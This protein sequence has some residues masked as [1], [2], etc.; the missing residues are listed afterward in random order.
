MAINVQGP[1]GSNFSFP[2]G[3]SSA[4]ITAA[5]DQ[6]FSGA[7]RGTPAADP[8]MTEGVVRSVATG[9]PV[10]GGL[11]NKLDA[12]TNAL[13]APLLDKYL[14]DS[15]AK[16][17][18]K[19][20]GERYSHALQLQK[21]MDK[22]FGAEHPV[23]DTAGQVAGG[24]AGVGA[25]L[26][27]A[28]EVTSRALGLT[29]ETLPQQVLH[30]AAGGA[31]LSA[32]DAATRGEDPE[33]SAEIGAITGAAAPVVGRVIGRGVQAL[34]SLRRPA[35]VATNLTDIAG[36]PVRQSLG[37]ATGDTEAIQ[38]EQMA[39][40]G[41]DNSSEQAVARD[42]FNRQKE[43]LGNAAHAVASQMNPTGEVVAENP[44]EMGS[45]LLDSLGQ[46][47]QAAA[48]EAAQRAQALQAQKGQV[49]QSLTAPG[50]PTGPLDAADV[51]SGEI[52]QARAAEQQQ[53]AQAAQAIQERAHALTSSLSPTGTV[54][55]A[56]PTEAANIVGQ[57]VGQAAESA[58]AATN[59]AY[60]G[61]RELPGRFDPAAFNKVGQEISGAL[62]RGA[63]PIKIDAQ[64]TPQAAAALN[65]LDEIVG[66]LRQQRDPATGQIVKG[67]P[68]TPNVVETARQ[69][70]NTFYRDALQ[71]ARASNNWADVRAMRGVMDAFDDA[72]LGRLRRG[73]FRGGD[74]QAVIDSME[75]ARGLHSNYRKTFTSQGA[76]DAVGQAM[77]KVVG[78]YEG[79]ASPPEE[80]RGML[81]GNG[82]LPVKLGQRLV[83]VFG[84]SSPEV[85]AIKQGYLSHLTQD[86]AG[87]ALAPEKAAGNIEGA[88]KSS[89]L[90]Q[91]YFSAPERQALAEHAAT[92]RA[93][94]PRP[95]A[96][97]DTVARTIPRIVGEGG[98]PMTA[99]ELADT[100]FGRQGV[101]ENQTGVKIVGHLK[102]TRG[103]QSP[104][105][106]AIRNGIF[107]RLHGADSGET[108]A[109]I[110]E[111]LNGRGKQ[112]ANVAFSPAEREQLARYGEAHAAEAARSSAPKTQ[113]DKIMDRLTGADNS[114]PPTASDVVQYLNTTKGTSRPVALVQRIKREFGEGSREVAALKQGQWAYLLENNTGPLDVGSRKVVSNIKAF[115][116]GPGKPLAHVL[117]SPQ[118]RALIK[119][120]GDLMERI[121]P[122]PGTV[123][124]SNTSTVLGKMMRGTLD[125]IF[126]AGGLHMA[127]PVGMLAGYPAHRVQQIVEDTVRASKVARS[128]YGTPQ[129]AA[130][131][132]DLARQ[133]QRLASVTA[134]AGTSKIAVG[135]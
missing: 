15:Y 59:A 68:L 2:D 128:L 13:L 114:A 11:A 135:Q 21:S 5:L 31:A 80:V 133:L 77:Q 131:A 57:S 72:V 69:R 8:G 85:G 54:L 107:N 97:T 4:D 47:G 130:A 44:Q 119:A 84:A 83:K 23:I 90:P 16:L 35:A 17:P 113:A 24:L 25:A 104:A 87:N 46:R 91:V 70:L 76:G 29:G 49:A 108:A 67:T 9:V 105:F 32:A 125:G 7:S 103:E 129:E 20:F 126:M 112:M 27:A 121:T 132:D 58:Q 123:N 39:L 134:R 111:F 82:A 26:K 6:H 79:Q 50:L 102:A 34:R 55:A 62:N 19:S 99:Q 93:S 78:R 18:E 94:V 14:P 122:P 43:E 120:Y 37:Q 73:L 95:V 33:S 98:Q 117:Y 75:S 118:E 81:Y 88:L 92:L 96:A 12:A 61:L 110:N 28:P 53:A 30:G 89:S 65:D 40:R 51:V 36:V 74:P 100:V 1:D 71:A 86:A 41:A 38:R 52:G 124:Y 106:Q 10:V 63:E 127:G 109:N 66:E 48:E 101:G 56:S 42:F 60:K 64:R 116:D 22:T 3:T 45:V 115:L